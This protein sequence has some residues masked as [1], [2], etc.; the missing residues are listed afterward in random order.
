[1]ARNINQEHADSLN[2]I[3]WLAVKLTKSVGTMWCFFAFCVLAIIPIVIPQSLPVVQFISSA[4]LQ[5]ILLPLIIVGSNLQNRHS[6]LRAE[7]EYEKTIALQC[8]IEQIK[9]SLRA[10]HYKTKSARNLRSKKGG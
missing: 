4:F 1:M 9:S 10:L 8:D 2:S 5:L 7:D 6:E 3:D